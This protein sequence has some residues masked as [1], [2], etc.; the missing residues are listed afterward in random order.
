MEPCPKGDCSDLEWA[1]IIERNRTVMRITERVSWNQG[2]RRALTV[3]GWW[4]DRRLRDDGD[5]MRRMNPGPGERR[6]L[7]SCE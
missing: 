1:E 6:S 3:M 4:V 2:G 5:G 7:S